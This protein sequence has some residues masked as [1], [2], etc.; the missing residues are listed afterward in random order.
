MEEFSRSAACENPK[1][2]RLQEQILSF[3]ADNA[4]AQGIV[5]C[6]TREMTYALL[7]WMNASPSLVAL[8]PRNITGSG[9][10]EKRNG[11]SQSVSELVG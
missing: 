3:Y 6:K 10:T 9:K 1:L 7:N 4:N 11:Q 5:F 2:R 8:K